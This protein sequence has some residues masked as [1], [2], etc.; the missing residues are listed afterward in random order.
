MLKKIISHVSPSI[1][2]AAIS[3]TLLCLMFAIVEPA[4]SIGA[5]TT[6]Q[7]TI[8]QT[9]NAEIAFATPASNVTMSPSLGGITGGTAN[10][11]T[12]VIVTTNSLGGYTMTLAASSS[13]G[14]IGNASSTYY[15]PAYVPSTGGVPDYTFT[16]PAN[17]ARFGYSV[18]ATTTSDVAQ[19]FRDNGSACNTG[20]NNTAGQ[21]WLNA[22]TSAVTIINRTT[23]T[24]ANGATTTINFRVGIS[25]NP[26]PVIPNDTYVATT[27]LTATTQ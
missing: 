17:A 27:T 25:S 1:R 8:S 7:F 19:L 10:G 4:V 21:C 15:I 26:N 5:T 13:L 20:S 9:V 16:V 18:K 2:Q 14:M 3:F 11:A 22:S 12:Q 23:P 6:S 24:P